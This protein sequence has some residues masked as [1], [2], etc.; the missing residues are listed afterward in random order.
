MGN[1]TQA[2]PPTA[3]FSIDAPMPL[4]VSSTRMI[5]TSRADG[6]AGEMLKSLMDQQGIPPS[7]ME[8]VM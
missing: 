5:E 6:C 3:D 2:F 4:R 8:P 7:P 1:M